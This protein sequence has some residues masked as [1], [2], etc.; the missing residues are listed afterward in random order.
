MPAKQN[1]QASKTPV[2]PSG[3][4]PMKHSMN[5]IEYL[6]CSPKIVSDPTKQV[7]ILADSEGE[8]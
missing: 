4:T 3:E 8:R 1:S 6:L 7:K 2:P 5:C